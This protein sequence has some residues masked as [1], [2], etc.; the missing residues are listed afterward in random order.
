[1]LI[2]GELINA[3]RKPIAQA[4]KTRDA[5]AIAG[6]ATLQYSCGAAFLNTIEAV[7]KG[8]PGIH[9]VCG[10]SNISYGLPEKKL[11]N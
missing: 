1:M 9:T 6:T 2:I 5:A 10:L 11:L 4:I 8:F 7:M 3:S